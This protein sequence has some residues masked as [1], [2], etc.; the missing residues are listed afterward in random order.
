MVVSILDLDARTLAEKIRQREVSVVEAVEAYC[1][2]LAHAN[3]HLNILAED[4]FAQA[5]AEAEACDRMLQQGNA[6]GKLFGVPITVKESLDVAGMKTTGGLL[7]RREHVAKKD[8]VVVEKLKREGAIILGKSNT[9]TL[10]F[11]QETDNKL[12]GRS[13]NPWDVSRT[14]GGSS[15]GE[16]ALIAI[17]GSAVGIGSDIGGSIRFPAHFNGVIGFKSGRRQVSQVGHFPFV[18]HEWQERML[19]IGALAKSVADAELIHAIIADEWL[20]GE[21]STACT[22]TIPPIRPQYPVGRE[23][24]ELLEQVRDALSAE[25]VIREDEPPLF[26]KHAQIWQ[27]IMSVDGGESIAR[28]ALDG[29]S[30]FREYVKEILFGRSDVHRYLSWALIG[31]RMFRPSGRQLKELQQALH[32]MDEEGAAYFHQN[33]LVLPVYHSPAPPHGTLYRELFSIRKTFLTYIPYVAVA[34]AMGLPALVI[35]V[36]ESRNGLPIAVQLIAAVGNEHLLFHVGKMIEKRFR[37]YKRC[38][39]FDQA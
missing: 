30:P 10:C 15:G 25:Y 21:R 35:P 23:T 24:A 34:N 17:G 31:A 32:R 22:V 26:D 8:A 7:H 4:R 6:E 39:A 29:R 19:G 27:L 18:E 13:N 20:D 12:F 36:G 3:P 28:L 9:P 33:V 1:R 37:G 16:G 2:H 38:R 5:R 11:C 14:T